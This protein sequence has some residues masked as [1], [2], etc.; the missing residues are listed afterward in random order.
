MVAIEDAQPIT[1]HAL[2]RLG[3]IAWITGVSR[4]ALP[5]TNARTNPGSVRFLC[6][7][8]ERRQG[9]DSPAGLLLR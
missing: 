4:W 8:A 9:L 7:R 6:A 5:D 2:L 3:D 1:G